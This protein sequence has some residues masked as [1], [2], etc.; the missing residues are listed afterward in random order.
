MKHKI[1]GIALATTIAAIMVA[2]SSASAFTF[3]LEAPEYPVE[4]TGSKVEA[5][6]L[7]GENGF[8]VK[9]NA[10]TL[11]GELTAAATELE[12]TPSYGECTAAGTAA[13]VS[14]EGCK[15][16]LDVNGRDMDIVCP[17]GKAIKVSAVTCEATIGAQSNRAMVEYPNAEEEPSSVTAKTSVKELKY[18]K[19]KDG[20]LC[21]FAGTGEKTDGGLSG[22][23]LLKGFVSK[24][25]VDLFVS[26]GC[27]P[28]LVWPEEYCSNW[29][30]MKSES[31]LE[32]GWAPAEETWPEEEGNPEE[33]DKK[34]HDPILFVH[35]WWGDIT[36]FATMIQ[37]FEAAGWP[38]SRL[39]NWQYKWWQ[40]NVTTAKEVETEVN[41]LLTAAKATEVDIITHS[42]GALSSRYYIKNLGGAKKVEDWVSLAGPNHGT[43][44]AKGCSLFQNS[45]KE[46]L[47]TSTFLKELNM[48]ETPAGPMYAT[49][50]SSCDGV[51][52]PETSV[53]LKGA[54]N[55]Q[56]K[57]LGHSAMHEDAGVFNEVKVFVER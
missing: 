18:T 9:C 47:S 29:E 13:T 57:C 44:I 23:S 17:A 46:M 15:Y 34:G 52:K 20:F 26:T 21:P 56:T 22:R 53:I 54:K 31:E 48:E 37:S 4:V 8:S 5:P 3:K 27:N 36:S 32:S 51:I 19:T 14:F 39:H 43:W 41:K 16:K 25:Q 33:Q 10:A 42:M 1:F 24:A 7:T 30:S 12:V 6:V 38:K 55:T 2:A 40:S 11:T 49:W 50:R 35:G 28:L 45:C